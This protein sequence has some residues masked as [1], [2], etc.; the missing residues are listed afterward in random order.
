MKGFCIP[1]TGAEARRTLMT[2]AICPWLSSLSRYLDN[3]V[4]RAFFLAWGRPPRKRPWERGWIFRVFMMIINKK[5]ERNDTGKCL[6]GPQNEV[7]PCFS[8]SLGAKQLMEHGRTH[9]R[10]IARTRRNQTKTKIQQNSW[11]SLFPQ[12]FKWH[13]GM[14]R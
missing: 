1:E 10:K 5:S 6:A 12:K 14:L 9:T 11:V 13:K 3:L 2:E 4:P 7:I 8:L